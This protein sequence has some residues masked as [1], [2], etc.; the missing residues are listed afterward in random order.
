MGATVSQRDPFTGVWTFRAEQS[1]LSTP[2]RQRW[3]ARIDVCGDGVQVREEIASADGSQTTL[4]VEARF[5]GQYYPFSGSPVADTIAYTRI[6]AYTISGIGKKEQHHFSRRNAH[7]RIGWK[8]HFERRD[9]PLRGIQPFLRD[10]T[11]RER[12]SR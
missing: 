6:D 2:P 12:E 11:L 1:K 3:V 10:V 5:D 4:T 8:L 7:R 9:H